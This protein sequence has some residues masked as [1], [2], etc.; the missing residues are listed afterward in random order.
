MVYF[1]YVIEERKNYNDG[2]KI[3]H[4]FKKEGIDADYG[5]N[6][7]G[8]GISISPMNESEIEKMNLICKKYD[9]TPIF[10]KKVDDL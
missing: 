7:K 6:E 4:E 8:S 10:I 5:I 2:T 1:R 9:I 3:T